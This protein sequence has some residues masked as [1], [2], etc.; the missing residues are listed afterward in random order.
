[1]FPHLAAQVVHAAII[2]EK[3]GQF[4]LINRPL[5]NT[6]QAKIFKSKLLP[7]KTSILSSG[8]ELTGE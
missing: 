1:L 2:A 4:R 8:M 3:V 7:V 5:R 6:P